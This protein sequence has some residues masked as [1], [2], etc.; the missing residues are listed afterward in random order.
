[1]ENKQVRMDMKGS[2]GVTFERESKQAWLG[3]SAPASHIYC[4]PGSDAVFYMIEE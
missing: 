3:H 1:M 2:L 4:H